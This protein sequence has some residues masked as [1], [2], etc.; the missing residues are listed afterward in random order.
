MVACNQGKGTQ[1]IRGQ[2]PAHWVV[3]GLRTSP[4]LKVYFQALLPYNLPFL[5]KLPQVQEKAD[6]LCYREISLFLISG[7]L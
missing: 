1:D 5:D 6:A 3:V 4:S 7:E 2:I